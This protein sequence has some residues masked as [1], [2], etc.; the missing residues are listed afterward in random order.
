MK[1]IDLTRRLQKRLLLVF[2]AS[3]PIWCL[4]VLIMNVPEDEQLA[5][6]LCLPAM[7]LV[8][9]ATLLALTSFGGRLTVSTAGL[10]V[11]RRNGSRREYPWANYRCLYKLNGRKAHFLLLTD[12]ALD[13]EAQLETC[14]ACRRRQPGFQPVREADGRLL[15][16]P[17]LADSEI[18]CR[19]PPHIVVA[20]AYR[21][22]RL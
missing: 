18:I 7:M 4:A 15:I 17:M 20:P 1:P 10:S 14:R 8:M 12:A 21:C 5:A 16:D 6:F 11:A 13:K 3:I 9:C 2:A 19:L 22:A